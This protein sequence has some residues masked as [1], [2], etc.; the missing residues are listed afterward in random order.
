MV[1]EF[2]KE[3]LEY[4]KNKKNKEFD[5][6]VKTI[7]NNLDQNLN[8]DL[9]KQNFIYLSCDACEYLLS[10][11]EDSEVLIKYFDNLTAILS[12]VE[13][14]EKIEISKVDVILEKKIKYDLK[15]A[16]N[17]IVEPPK[18]I[19]ENMNDENFY[20]KMIDA[21][22]NE[23]IGFNFNCYPGNGGQILEPIKKFDNEKI[24]MVIISE[25]DKKYLGY[26]NSNSTPYRIRKELKNL[27]FLY[28]YIELRYKNIEALVPYK[29]VKESLKDKSIEI[30][31]KIY[32]K[33]NS[34]EWLYYFDFKVG[35]EKNITDKKSKI[36]NEE[37][38]KWWNTQF[39]DIDIYKIYEESPERD[40]FKSGILELKNY[41]LDSES[42][43]KK[44]SKE[45][46]EEYN[47]IYSESFSWLIANDYNL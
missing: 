17:L 35:I 36:K 37:S 29:I 11:Y 21:I 24:P 15:M 43:S 31:N 30:F 44:S 42:F 1:I 33:K 47:R 5:I 19:I 41:N 3:I 16:Q 32:F 25:H 27:K 10:F 34:K 2:T 6:L 14:L 39:N 28:N 23:K 45:Q 8:C 26:E 20:K 13:E 12:N 9:M 7:I 38:I 40:I 18:I 4:I 22:N 46:L